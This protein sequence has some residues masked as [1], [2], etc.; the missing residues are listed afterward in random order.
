MTR[1]QWIRYRASRK[2]AQSGPSTEGYTLKGGIGNGSRGR[3]CTGNHIRTGVK[4][5]PQAGRP[6]R[7]V[8]VE[9]KQR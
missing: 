4:R 6:C 7:W 9:G 5:R 2:V 3:L 1:N 8:V